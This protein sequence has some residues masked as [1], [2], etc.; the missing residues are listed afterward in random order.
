[1][2]TIGGIDCKRH[3]AGEITFCS[4]D[5][6]GRKK[7]FTIRPWGF[8]NEAEKIL[9]T[10]ANNVIKPTYEEALSKG[11]K[12]VC[13][14]CKCSKTVDKFDRNEKGKLGVRPECKTCR[15]GGE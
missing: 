1:M 8:K 14:S 7:D 3:S 13:S 9:W 12:K 11:T 10:M 5:V 15:K 2:V 6:N 4:I